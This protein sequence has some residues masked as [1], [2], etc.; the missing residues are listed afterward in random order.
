MREPAKPAVSIARATE[1]RAP[2]Q[3]LRCLGDAITTERS[4][5]Q[6]LM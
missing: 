4:A 3:V 6:W 1:A 2:N 5:R